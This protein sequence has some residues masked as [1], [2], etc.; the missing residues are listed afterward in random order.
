V[1][2]APRLVEV[3]VENAVEGCVRETFGAVMAHVQALRAT[4]PVVRS[5][6][7]RIAVDESRHAALAWAVH[8][9]GC[10]R[11]R[12]AERRRIDDARQRA[13]RRLIDEVERGPREVHETEL[14]LIGSAEARTLAAS[15][16]AHLWNDE[17]RAAA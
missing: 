4:D 1:R 7:A 3:L 15:L 6:M 10:T 8:A 11:M 5:T 17:A 14:G 13:V 9:W 16:V 2:R 12:P